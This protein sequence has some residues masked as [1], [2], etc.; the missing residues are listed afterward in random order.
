MKITQ[1]FK[2]YWPGNGGGIAT[3]MER[4]ADGCRDWE[5]EIIVCQDS[6]K[7]RC[8]DSH[9]HG[10]AVHRCRQLFEMASTPVSFQF[11]L[12][13]KRRTRDSDIVVCHF[14][15][16]MADLAVLFGMYSGRL[17]VWWHCGFE[18]DRK[19]AFLY[20]P[21]VRH[22]LQKADRILV[23]SRGNLENTGMLRKYRGK[24][25]VVPFCISDAYRKRGQ[26]HAEM[27]YKEKQQEGR[28]GCGRS[29]VSILFI[30]RFVWYKG[31]DILLRAFARMQYRDCRLVLV[32]SGPLEREL[33]RLA[34]SLRLKNVL[35]AGRVSEE[36]K[37]RQIE[38]CDFLVL[39]SVSEAEAFAI[40][41]LEAMAFGKPVINTRLKS[42]VPYVSIGGV[43]GITVK[44][45]SVKELASAMDE[46]A[47]DEKLRRKYGANA[48]KL[49]QKEYT[50]EMMV[51]R[52]RRIFEKLVLKDETELRQNEDCI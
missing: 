13:V 16:P 48:L 3:V 14:P 46:L 15:Y 4:I 26:A 47:G 38:Q 45:G 51:N 25:S 33:K 28:A 41:Q 6:R 39:P 18:K 11:L 9:Y 22:T 49:V 34:A 8:A 43:T 24:C 2:I 7:K 19:L 32:G 10:I 44:P 42:G 30:G 20:R 40:V 27:F 35:F 5:Q 21:L 17:V 12:D 36:E 23:S 50:Q 29:R 31:C 1:I 37:L 52:H